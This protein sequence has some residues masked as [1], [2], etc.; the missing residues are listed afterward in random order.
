MGNRV[1]IVDYDIPANPAR[2]RV[3]FY[4]D[5]KKLDSSSLDYST[6]SVFCTSDKMIAHAV[7]LLVKAH[8]GC[9]HV[10][11]GEEVTDEFM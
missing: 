3:Q 4:R 6:L 9:G 2:K 10:Y 8:G 1:Y 7:Y 11:C 5:L